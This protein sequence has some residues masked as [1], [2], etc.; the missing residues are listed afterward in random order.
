[1]FMFGHHVLL[2]AYAS[3]M[4]N[5]ERWTLTNA[6]FYLFHQNETERYTSFVNVFGIDSTNA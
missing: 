5:T 1:M 2:N 4:N 3:T 6:I